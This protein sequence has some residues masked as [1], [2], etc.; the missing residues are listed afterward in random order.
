MQFHCLQ[1]IR[2]YKQTINRYHGFHGR[3]PI[4]FLQCAKQDENGESSSKVI[5]PKYNENSN[6]FFTF[7]LWVHVNPYNVWKDKCEVAWVFFFV[8]LLNLNPCMYRQ[9]GQQGQRPKPP[10]DLYWFFEIFVRTEKKNSV[11]S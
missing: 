11:S 4:F 10:V 1:I 9:C 6:E 3:S 8:F 5:Y 7:L 2:I